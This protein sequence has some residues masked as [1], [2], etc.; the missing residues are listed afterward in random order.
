MVIKQYNTEVKYAAAFGWANVRVFDT[1]PER[2]LREVF[3]S[4]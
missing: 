1:P 2:F 4:S 3:P